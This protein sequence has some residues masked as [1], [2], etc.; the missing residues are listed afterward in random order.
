MLS[1]RISLD[2]TRVVQGIMTGIGVLGAGVIFK[3]ALAVRGQT[4]AAS[5]WITATMGIL[6]GIGFFSVLS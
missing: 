6:A 3:E 1:E 5:I 4:T 2:P